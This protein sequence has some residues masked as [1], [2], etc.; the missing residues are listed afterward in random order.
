MLFCWRASGALSVALGCYVWVASLGPQA[1][2][3]TQIS[4]LLA[5]HGVRAGDTHFALFCPPTHCS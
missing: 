2:S 4:A 1:V 5:L 3:V